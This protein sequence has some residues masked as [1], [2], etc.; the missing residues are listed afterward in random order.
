VGKSAEG[1]GLSSVSGNV[2]SFAGKNIR[3]PRMADVMM[4]DCPG[5][6]ALCTCTMQRVREILCA[7]LQLFNALVPEVPG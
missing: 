3:K 2:P 4:A 1:V 7:P 6:D 5:R